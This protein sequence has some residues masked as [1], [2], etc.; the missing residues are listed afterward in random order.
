MCES[1]NNLFP[2]ENKSSTNKIISN[3]I[4]VPTEQ[5]I[6]NSNLSNIFVTNDY[7]QLKIKIPLRLIWYPEPDITTFELA[8]CIP[9]INKTDL[10]HD[11]VFDNENNILSS[12]E[13]LRHFKIIDKNE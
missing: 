7:Q 5:C 1:K 6:C 4:I 2:E 11:D 3:L 8:C 9:Y 13:F 12:V 10:Y